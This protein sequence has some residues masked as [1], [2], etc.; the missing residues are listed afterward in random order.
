M[1]SISFFVKNKNRTSKGGEF[2][3]AKSNKAALENMKYEVANSLGVNMKKGYN[4]D[5]SSKDNG[6][7]GGEMVRRMVE[8]YEQN[9]K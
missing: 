2:I 4:G 5:L 3:M 8:Q 1:Y 7:V 6:R 9:N